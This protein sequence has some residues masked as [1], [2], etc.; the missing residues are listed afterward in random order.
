MQSK[1][2]ASQISKR[3]QTVRWVVSDPPNFVQ[4]GPNFYL[5]EVP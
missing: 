3:I 1:I 5:I 4:I 2:G